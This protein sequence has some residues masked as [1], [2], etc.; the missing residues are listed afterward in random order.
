MLYESNKTFNVGDKI[1]FRADPYSWEY[2]EQLGIVRS[3]D[4]GCYV[5]DWFDGTTD[6]LDY[7]VVESH[8]DLME[9]ANPNLKYCYHDW[10]KYQGFTKVYEY[11][12][13]CDLKK[14]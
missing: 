1:K 2:S 5:I 12:K 14:E 13:K 3:K 7:R 4:N 6:T 8:C 9:A 11:C 10:V